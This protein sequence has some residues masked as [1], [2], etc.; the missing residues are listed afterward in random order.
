[1]EVVRAPIPSGAPAGPRKSLEDAI[2]DFQAI[3]TD[4]QRRKLGSIGAIQD[5]D[6][7][8]I[9]TAQLDR[10]NQLK[11]GRGIASRLSSVLQSVQTFST[12]VDTFV[13]SHPEIAA[14]VWGSIKLAMLIAVN[15][16]SY[17]EA[18]SVLFMELSKQCPRFAEYQALYT[19]STRLQKALCDFHA[20]IIRCCK[21]VVE[22]VQRPWQKQLRIAFFQSFEQEFEPDANDIQRLG[23]EVEDEIKLAKAQTDRQDQMLQEKERV[24]ALKQRSRLRKFIPKVERQL[25]SIKELQIQRSTRR[26]MKERQRLLKSLSSHDYVTPFQEARKKHQYSTAEWIF[27]T[28]EFTRW[29]DG[30]G[31]VLLW[32]SGKIGSGKTILCA[33]VINHV[34]IKKSRD[35]RAAFFFLQY[36]NSDSLTAETI[37]R[38]II[39]Q[40]MDAITVPE[41]VEY[42]LQE[43]DRKHFVQL[44]DWAFLLRQRIEHSGIFFVFIDGL[45]ECSTAERRALLD[46]LSSL[47]TTTLGLRIFIA[48]RDS[49]Y[50]D[51]KGRFSHMEHV[52]MAPVNLSSDIRIY[53]EA[54]VQERMR[55]E[56]L[57][58]EDPHLLNEI[59]DTL[60]RHADGMFLWVTFLINEVCIASCDHD[61]R[62]SL[63]SLPKDLEETFSRA[64][65]RILSRQKKPELVQKVF[66]WVAVA[67]RPLTLDEIREAISISVGQPY[68]NTERRV[69]EMS[70]IILWCENLLQVTEE[71]PQSLQFAHSSIRDFITRGDLP[72][73]LS[74]FHVDLEAADHF[75]G[76]ICVTYLHL[77]NFKTTLARRSQSL[78]V[79]PV[80][81][82]GTALGRGTKATELTTRF[83]DILGY[84]KGKGNPDLAGTLVG[85]DRADGLEKLQQNY[86]FLKYASKHW[87]SHTANFQKARSSSWNLWYHIITNGHVLAHVP[88]QESILHRNEETILI[89]SHQR[90][91]YAILRYANSFPGLPELKRIELMR[92]SASEGD[93]EAIAIFLDAEC[94]MLCIDKTLHAAS[95]S[96]HIQVV[97]R[98][99]EAGAHVNTA[100]ATAGGRTALQAASEGGHIQVVERLLY[101]GADVKA[102]P[103]AF[104]EGRTALQ[105]AS[106][107]GHIQVVERLLH[108]G[109]K[110]NA[111]AADNGGRTALQVASEGGH[112]QVVER[113]LDAGADF[114]AAANK[115]R[116]RTAL[117]AASAGGHIQVIER[118]LHAGVDVNAATT[119]AGGR[120]AL[121]AASEGG[122]IQVV[123][124]LLDVGADVNAATTT[125][126]GRTALEA[127]SAGGHIQVIERLLEAGA[128][129]NAAA[130]YGGRTALQ[131][132]SEGGHIQVA[133]RLLKAG[134]K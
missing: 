52:S 104:T 119:T 80:A 63:R 69:R 29:Y 50:V 9:F 42:Q 113:L 40:S 68:L 49:V 124:R 66:R 85:Y 86:P 27:T 14:L 45:D 71:K 107:G 10:D 82:A 118:L 114:N 89:W 34:L 78:R 127:A 13:A 92:T 19:T 84:P 109:A 15:Y 26:S 98:L 77:N 55:D 75:A 44:Q 88:W 103:A 131:A 48:S 61:I 28:P 83:A 59:R 94:T 126:G 2:E 4:D 5:P 33:N 90:H 64:L 93:D 11:K 25:D 8:M 23:K 7:V 132:A 20:S 134:A 112:I 16:T 133:K 21:H 76:E 46:V 111:A 129:A 115:H 18:L 39:R 106:A 31:P 128:K 81:M 67:K 122:H 32:C 101:A 6:T 117:Q 24:D 121:E 99:L 35:D 43:L 12:V 74:D 41:H 37:I 79:N 54:T 70:P 72:I 47:A 108:A 116:G 97:E 110:V 125:A 96:G 105:A 53:V 56:D 100:T 36:D 58:C 91:H 65:S 123:E 51:L 102:A 87:V 57:V 120:T 3:L 38:S 95:G 130:T 22:A 73:Q 1:M 30:T 17:F 62:Q 60:T